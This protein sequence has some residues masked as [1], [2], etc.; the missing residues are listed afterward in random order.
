MS[1]LLLIVAIVVAILAFY[2]L[3]LR[4]RLIRWGATDAE[5]RAPFPGA[6]LIPGGVRGTTMAVTIDAPPSAV[7]PW[8]AQMG[9]GRAVWYTWDYWRPWGI[10]SA[11]EIHPE[12]QSIS[13]GHHMASVPSGKIWWEVASLEPERFLGLRMTVD[14]L[15]RRIDSYAPR[16]RGF[17]DSL[18]AFLLAPLPSARTRLLVSGY[19][20]FRPRW[21]RGLVQFFLL[22]PSTW[23]M[24]TRQF[25]GLKQR[26]ERAWRLK[27]ITHSP[28]SPSLALPPTR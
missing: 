15:G 6:E 5:Q 8:L 10:R 21:L 14:G 24:Q 3:A 9:V 1:T 12:W 13:I 11:N 26:A 27:Q 7:W 4:P 16:P 18:W 19:W 25:A 17:S 22:E 2:A 20:A 23:L 28:L